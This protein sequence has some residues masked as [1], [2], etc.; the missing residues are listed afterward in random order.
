VTQATAFEAWKNFLLVLAGVLAGDMF[1]MLGS[2]DG[3]VHVVHSGLEQ[4]LILDKW[5]AHILGEYHTVEILTFLIII[6]FLKCYHG[7]FVGIYSEGYYKQLERGPFSA[8]MLTSCATL[9]IVSLSFAQWFSSVVADQCTIFMRGAALL[10]IVGVPTIA[11][12]VF[13][14]SRLRPQRF[15]HDVRKFFAKDKTFDEVVGTWIVEDIVLFVIVFLG[16]TMVYFQVGSAEF[17]ENVVLIVFLCVLLIPS[18]IDYVANRS[19]FFGYKT[20][21]GSPAAASPAPVP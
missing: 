4:F 2:G 14:I 8:M 3:F 17:Q 6:Y 15:F 7:I 5:H 12:M 18:V 20:P 16:L 11:L 19:F 10:G 21:P 13:D 9:T 1:S